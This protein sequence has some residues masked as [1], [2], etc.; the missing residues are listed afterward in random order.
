MSGPGS[1]TF[2]SPNTPKTFVTLSEPGIYVLRLTASD[3]ELTAS[4]DVTITILANHAPV[5]DAGG[6]QQVTF[7]GPATLRGSVS[8]DGLPVG[9]Q[10]SA[11]WTKAIGPGRVT[12][13]SPTFSSSDDFSVTSNPSRAWS[14]GWAPTRGA[15]FTPYLATGQFFGLPGW[16]RNN[17]AT[18]PFPGFYPLIAYNDTGVP[19][20]F[21]DVTLPAGSL[22]LHPGPNGENSVLRWTAPNAG[23]FLVQGRF[24][25]VAN[26]TTADV[27]V[28]LN[29]ATTLF[30]GDINGLGSG[31]PFTFAR[32]LNAGDTLDFAVGFGSDGN[33]FSD[34]TGLTVSITQAGDAST[35]ASF[36][37]PGDYVLRLAGFDSELFGFSDVRVRVAPTCI[38]PPAGIAGWWPGDGNPGDLINH[39]TGI[40][41][42]G[43]TYGPGMVGKA[44]AFNGVDADVVVP[45]SAALSVQS[46]TLDAWVFPGDLKSARPILEYSGANGPLG[47]HLWMNINPSVV[48]TPGA[49]FTNIVDTSGVNHVFATGAG[50][51]QA[52]QWNH[53]ALTYN[54]TTGAARLYVNGAALAVSNL[55]S[56]TPRTSLPLNFGMRPP[57]SPVGLAGARFVGRIDEVEVFNR[58]LAPS[59]VLSIFTAGSAG[60]CKPS[61]PQP[62]IV[63][64]GPNQT[65]TLPTNTVTLNGTATDPAGSPLTTSWSQVSGPGAVAFGTPTLLTTTASFSAAGIYILSLTASNAQL[66]A[67]SDVTINVNPGVN[68]PP[69]VS[70]GPNQTITL[71]ANTVTLRGTVT[72]DGLPFGGKLTQQWSVVSGPGPVTFSNSTQPVTQTTFTIPGTYVL[73]LTA[74]DSQLSASATTT[75]V[76]NPQPNQPPVVNPGPNQ[77]IQLPTNTVTLNGTVT[78]TNPPPAGHPTFQWSQVSGP[79]AVTFSNPTSLVTQAAFTTAGTYVLQLSA[80]DSQLTGTAPVTITVAAAAAQNQP[81][82]VSA[83]PNQTITLPTNTVTLN[84]TVTDDGLPIGGKLTQQWSQVS[85]PAPVTFSS[86]TQPVTQASFTTAGTYVL[87]LTASD[88]QLT[89][90]ATTSV[91]VN[92]RPLQP[93]VVSAGPN[94]TIQLPTNVVTLNGSA[95][96]PLAAPLTIAWSQV[97]GP[98]PVTFGTPTQPVTQASFTTAG[99]YVL[100]LSA[101][102]SQFVSTSNVTVNVLA[103]TAQ[104]QPPVVTVPGTQTIQ[105]PNNIV[106]LNGTVTDDGLPIGGK[107]TQVWSVV[108]G[109]GPVTFGNPTQPVTQASFSASGNYVLQLTASDSQLTSS[110]RTTVIVN[111]PQNQPPV[112]TVPGNQTIQLPNNIAILNGT[113]T[114]DGLPIGGTLTIAWSK[115][116]GPGTVTFAN[117]GVAAT[118][119]SF[120]TAG[121][122]VLQLTANDS[123]L[124]TTIR[125]PAAGSHVWRNGRTES[126]VSP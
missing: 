102:N 83:G 118:T 85:G 12:F 113:V 106:T 107:L 105:L 54:Q 15:G 98:A 48:V 45:A 115:V 120:S 68:Q 96:D 121:T 39:N 32:T 57:G 42:G 24:I 49:L 84:G 88:S 60:K 86:P 114:D 35:I 30:N 50:A 116:S 61:G 36:N 74:N 125:T 52:N 80:T 110:A 126:A 14:Y 81:P 109:L 3:S 124:T 11:F 112:V 94:Q 78:D 9:G 101:K 89:S 5:V 111:P 70:A 26:T 117:A 64:A 34:S 79:A 73:Q 28:L 55:G 17:P 46:F 62:P 59:E 75:V 23:T 29:S 10:L 4:S 33:F 119:A 87:Q 92:P 16:F 95:T 37:T 97:S 6:E 58:A 38:A 7:P 72:D 77:T 44:F 40:T 108:S 91:V 51:L 67:S 20:L 65:I 2:S 18:T 31:V 47:V 21:V 69:I 71:P 1:A 76:V 41:E 53:V 63:S 13:S 104:N 99:T 27:A 122:Y 22:L 25:G 43:L 8:D 19:A 82:V 56:F 100:Q 103:A 93:P 66:T 123:Q 90:S